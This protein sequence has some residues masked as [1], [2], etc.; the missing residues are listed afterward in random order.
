MKWAVLPIA[1]AACSTHGPNCD[2]VK[3]AYAQFDVISMRRTACYGTCP[4]YGVEISAD[5]TFTY[6]GDEFVKVK[7]VR[8]GT[9]AQED[10]AL[11]SSALRHARFDRM[12]ATYQSAADG[13]KDLATDLPSFSI[14]V[15][16]SGKTRKVSFYTGCQGPSI[17]AE[18]LHWLAHT[19]DALAHTAQFVN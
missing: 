2:N 17:P 9:L 16:T 1:L 14:S 10:I 3:P 13:C 18:D 8:Q 7:G 5:G 12:R 19:V 15:T 6:K 4:V 11:L